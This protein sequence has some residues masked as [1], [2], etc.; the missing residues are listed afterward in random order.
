MNR[1]F[2]FALFVFSFSYFYGLFFPGRG[3]V[4]LQYGIG[5]ALGHT[6]T[7]QYAFIGIDE[8]LIIFHG[9][10]LV[11]ADLETFGASNTGHAAVLLRHGTLFLVDTAHIN[12]PVFFI[13]LPEFNNV[14]RTGFNAGT[15]SCTFVINDFRKFCDRVHMNGIKIA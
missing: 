7:A 11:L 4:Q 14:S 3:K 8:G 13:L 5:G 9:N 2:I 10:G 12:F 15:T 6:F 1:L